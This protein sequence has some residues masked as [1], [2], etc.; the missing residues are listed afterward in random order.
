MVTKFSVKKIE[1]LTGVTNEFTIVAVDIDE[2]KAV[3]SGDSGE[4]RLW[5][6]VYRKH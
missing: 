3:K 2:C 4:S 6:S 1:F 5:L